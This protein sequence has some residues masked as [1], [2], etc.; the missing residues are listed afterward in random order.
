M[1]PILRL[2]GV[3][4]D[5]ERELDEEIAAHLEMTQTALRA[6]GMSEV[7]AREEAR[8]RFGDLRAHR[9]AIIRLEEGRWRRMRMNERMESLAQTAKGAW[10]SMRRAPAFTLAIVVTLGLGLGANAV[11]FGVVD[12]L[13]LSPPQHVETADEVVRLYGQRR[14]P[15]GGAPFTS[16][17][18]SW[19]DIAMLGQV[20]GFAEVAG[21]R[22]DR[23]TLGQGASARRVDVTRATASIFALTGVEPALGRFYTSSEDA[24]EAPR[25]AVLSHEFWTRAYGAD[26][27]V[28]GRQLDIENVRWEVVGVAPA[29]FTGVELAPVDVWLPLTSFAYATDD[30]ICFESVNC[31]WVRAVARLADREREAAVLEAASA[32]HVGLR[33]DR[34][35][36]GRFDP[37]ARIVAGPITGAGGPNPD[38]QANVALWLGGVS[39]VVLLI[40]CANVA[41]MLL[42]R[43]VRLR[44]ELAIRISLGAGRRRLLADL[45]AESLMLAA[46]GAAVAAAVAWLGSGALHRSLLPNVAFVDEGLVVRLG[47]F[48]LLAT[49][50]TGLLA[51]IVPALQASSAGAAGAAQ[52]ATRRR[53]RARVALLLAQSALSVL[54]L[55]GAGLFVRSLGQA[56][57]VDLGYDAQRVAVVEFEW[58]IEQDGA[59]RTDIYT[60][61]L[62]RTAAMP[63]VA[64]V[65]LTYTIPFWTAVGGTPRI[66]GLE[67]YPE[68]DGGG[69]YLNKVGSGY[70]EAMGIAV[71]AGR[72]FTPADD[73]M[74]VEPVAMITRSMAQA[75]WPD[76]EALGGCMYFEDPGAD[77][78]ADEPCTR[79]VGI[80]ENH[81]R[82]R[83]DSS[84]PDHMYYVNIHHPTL[85][86]P[87]QALMVRATGDAGAIVPDL[88][89]VLSTVDPT[90]R[91]V[92]ARPLE[93]HIEPQRRS[94]RLGATMFALFGL[95]ALVVAAVGLY[96]V[97]SFEVAHRRRE[98]GVRAAL[99]AGKRRLLAMVLRSSLTTAV[100]GFAV[101]VTG[102]LFAAR[103]VE[104]LLFRV[105]PRDPAVYVGVGAVILAVATLAALLPG[106]RA[107]RVDPSEA[108]RAE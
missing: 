57:G 87:P 81:V 7:E 97:L 67:A 74:D 63:G 48:L 51:G 35:A 41:N 71:A 80:L 33:A 46:L 30:Q 43:A 56:T 37:G 90:V 14:S 77:G 83:L 19:R 52:K 107:T 105:S 29:G 32:G 68:L 85:R 94:F 60:R 58:T 54:L 49:L 22:P 104:P 70:L 1:I 86:G 53:S 2:F 93:D 28:I 91:F 88:A 62:Q 101:G 66:P 55:I 23:R 100:A 38:A 25:V 3:V 84:Q 89:R 26:P 99:G 59:T 21:Y 76:G 69:P 9:R 39:L 64:G 8:R 15:A 24:P 31:W 34:V 45:L 96:S 65:G 50:L 44:Q 103:R 40:A 61:A 78:A 13:L 20:E 47:L 5:P 16:P 27:G 108:M 10:R 75:G 106:W 6:Q 36:D 12:R 73:R 72:S 79:V 98:L 4:P 102:A 42:S 17:S 95:L 82:E 92:N 11:M 18:L